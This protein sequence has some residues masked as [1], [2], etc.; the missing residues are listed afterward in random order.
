MDLLKQI[1]EAGIVGAGG[2]G[3][4]THKKFSDG[5]R[6]LLINAA[7]CEPLLCSDRF[8]MRNYASE[9]IEALVA[10][11]KEFRIPRVVIG[12]KKKYVREIAALSRE[13]ESR[14]LDIEIFTVSSFYPAGD[15][16]IL[17]YE[18]L[19]ETVPP[20]GIPPM[21]N[22]AVINA[23]TALNI[24]R[25][26]DGIKVTRHY[27][28]VNGAV[29]QPVIVDAPVGARLPDI[30]EA[31]GGVSVEPYSVIKGG[32]MMGAQFTNKESADLVIGKAD[33]GIIV[34]SESHPLI[35]FSSKSIKHMILRAKSVCIQCSYCTEMCPRYLIGHRLRPNRV[36]RSLATGTCDTDLTD[37]LLCCECGVCELFA[38]PM[39]LS[40]RRINAYVKGLL[41]E[42]GISNVDKTVHKAQ[43]ELREFRRVSQGRIIN[44][45][46]LGEYPT[47][48]D[49]SV[50][51]DPAEVR[52]PLKHG[53]GKPSVPTVKT[54]DMVKAGSVIAGV[55]FSDVG[56]MIHASIDGVVTA[57]DDGGITIKRREDVG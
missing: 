1:Y 38:C 13:I 23:T 28:T 21:L 8:V 31:A 9:I 18:V 57:V 25:A 4:P 2:A 27:V 11:K 43:T 53:V 3:F 54:G 49:H 17:I 5:L 42:Q 37:A 15:E 14:G 12:T 36:M 33:G 41:H 40:P 7:E 32:P 19:S 50:R 52:I 16:Q 48:I 45:L 26:M 56:C 47:E 29:G 55:E 34:L 22:I 30:I 46:M 10:L 6:L 20:G 24:H 44:R 39:M 35:R 51:L